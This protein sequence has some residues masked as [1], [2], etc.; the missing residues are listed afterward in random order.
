MAPSKAQDSPPRER[1]TLCLSSV[2][3]PSAV[4]LSS[5][6]V[7][8]MPIPLTLVLS[9]WGENEL[10]TPS[11]LRGEGWG[12]GLSQP[13]Y[14]KTR[15]SSVFTMNAEPCPQMTTIFT[16]AMT[17]MTPS[18]TLSAGLLNLVAPNVDPMNPPERT[19]TDQK[20]M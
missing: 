1:Q 6:V 15:R 7:I 14:I 16:P 9:P 2:E 11:P 3:Q 4:N 10:H 20:A 17:S 19:A 18:N 12:E 8:V 13:Y 5:V